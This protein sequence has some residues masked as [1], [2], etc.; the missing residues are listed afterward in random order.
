M[1]GSETPDGEPNESAW[2]EEAVEG[3]VEEIEERGDEDD[4]TGGGEEDEND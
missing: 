4:G 2:N 3:Q 1:D